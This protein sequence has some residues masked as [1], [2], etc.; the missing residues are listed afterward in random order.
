MPLEIKIILLFWLW[1]ENSAQA[2]GTTSADP[3]PWK[4]SDLDPSVI[5]GM[6]LKN[7]FLISLF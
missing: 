2:Q 4:N 7:F 6:I 5:F 3:F 1:F